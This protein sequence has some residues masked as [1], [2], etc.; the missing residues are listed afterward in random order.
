MV[1][2]HNFKDLCNSNKKKTKQNKNRRIKFPLHALSNRMILF[3][4]F[5][6]FPVFS[7]SCF[8]RWVQLLCFNFFTIL[9]NEQKKIKFILFYNYYFYMYIYSNKSYHKQKLIIFLHINKEKMDLVF[10]L[11]CIFLKLV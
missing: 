5:L 7:F 9:L 2:W 10:C 4:R 6:I 1:I 8:V 3:L 11:H